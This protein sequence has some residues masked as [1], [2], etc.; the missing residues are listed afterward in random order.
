ML[1]FAI[2]PTLAVSILF[3]FVSDEGIG[4]DVAALPNVDL[5][6]YAKLTR[7]VDLSSLVILVDNATTTTS[8]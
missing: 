8:I 2:L 1:L 6:L 7:R 4:L 3:H 5:R